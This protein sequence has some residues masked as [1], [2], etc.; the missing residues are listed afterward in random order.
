MLLSFSNMCSS[1]FGEDSHVDGCSHQRVGKQKHQ[2][3]NPSS[4]LIGLQVRIPSNKRPL[5]PR[6]WTEKWFQPSYYYSCKAFWFGDKSRIYTAEKETFHFFERNASLVHSASCDDPTDMTH[7]FFIMTSF[8]QIPLGSMKLSIYLHLPQTSSKHRQICHTSYGNAIAQIQYTVKLLHLLLCFFSA[9][10]KGSW[11]ASDR[12]KARGLKV[13]KVLQMI[14]SDMLEIHSYS[15]IV[16]SF[17]GLPLHGEI[18]QFG[19]YILRWV[20]TT[21]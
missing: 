19:W 14:G 3:Q 11:R 16:V 2:T 5:R 20:E 21:N 8:E 15:N 6:W 12:A 4:S 1:L 17:F 7:D 13:V 10:R 9:T 18:I